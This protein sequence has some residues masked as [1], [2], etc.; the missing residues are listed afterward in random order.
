MRAQTVAEVLA[1]VLI[2]LV[3]PGMVTAAL[4]LAW[5]VWALWWHRRQA[6]RAYALATERAA[7]AATA[8]V[9]DVEPGPALPFVCP[10]C[11]AESWNPND[12]EHGYCARCGDWT[13]DPGL[14]RV[15]PPG[16]APRQRRHA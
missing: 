3:L 15:T 13:G 7:A 4:V 5:V 2:G 12:L 16:R 10:L 1:G 8:P 9:T 6:D 11:G 14:G